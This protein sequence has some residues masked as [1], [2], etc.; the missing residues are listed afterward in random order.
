MRKIYLFGFLFSLTFLLFPVSTSFAEGSK[1]IYITTHNTYLFSCNDAVGQCNNGGPR[2]RFASYDGPEP[3]RLYFVTLNPSETVYLGFNGILA[4]NA[5]PLAHIVFRIKDMSGTVVYSEQTMPN[6]GTGFISNI[7][8]ARTGPNQIYTTGG[9]DAYN[10]HPPTPGTYYLE[11]TRKL[12]V[13]GNIDLGGIQLN[14]LDVTVYDT[15]ASQV[16]PGRLYSKSWQFQESSNCSATT[17]I[18]SVDSITTSCQ[19][20]N[21]QGGI[22]VQF[23][24]QWGCQNT[25]NFVVDR[26]SRTTQSLLPQ[27]GRAHV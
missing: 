7:G 24:N 15:I 23:C 21:M 25:G 20:N 26:K 8:A 27:I 17:Y 6:S 14:L 11:M 4:T 9:Y 13:N 18:Y 19:F 1:E 12:N 5:N 16:K 2:T 10:F 22:W 3:D